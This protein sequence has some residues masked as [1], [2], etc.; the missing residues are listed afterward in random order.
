MREDW[1][2][3]EFSDVLEIISGKNQKKVVDYDGKYPIYGSGGI[4]GKANDF[5]CESGTTI[6]G[7]KGTIN[8]PIYVRS[9][10]WNVDTAFGLSPLWILNNRLLFFFSVLYNFTALDKSTA[11]PSLA[12]RDLLRIKFPLPPIPIQTSIVA[13]IEELFTHLDNGIADL[14]KAQEQLKIYRQAVLKKAFEGDLTKEWREK[15]T[16]LPSADELLEQIKLDFEQLVGSKKKKKE[17][18]LAKIKAE[19][20]P[21]TIPTKWCWCNF[22]EV[23]WFIN[24]DRGKNYPNRSEYVSSG[25]P[26]INTG[27]IN[28][29][30][31]LSKEK[32]NFITIEKFNSLR[33]GK[34]EKGDLVYC[35]RG[36]TFGKTAFVEPYTEGSIASSLMIIRS[37]D[38]INTK[39]LYHYL[40][41]VEG[42]EQLQRFDN[43]T[44]QPNLSANMVRS[45]AFPL[46]S[47]DE[48]HQMVQKI[49]SRLSVC[50]KV[51]ESIKESL[52]KAE[53]L[54]QS[55]LKKA[56]EGKLLSS[57]VIARCKQS[58]D[59]EPASVLLDRIKNGKN[60]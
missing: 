56:F 51:E 37:N 36:A 50:D 3:C 8:S 33:S 15:Q 60:G 30:G 31:S 27:H 39:Y 45:Y 41:S 1:V 20:I 54:R 19:D 5:L 52:E 40:T 26:W 28:P 14:K 9:K 58:K 11:V 35:L 43:G 46:P 48:Q 23:V 44:A 12:K 29:D 59:Y 16:H 18:P 42:K 55:I 22:G 57:A 17:K 53:A 47:T 25:I 32:M 10:F 6:I 2:E 13:K 21:H 49:E 7:R 24:G 38:K 4:I 34:I